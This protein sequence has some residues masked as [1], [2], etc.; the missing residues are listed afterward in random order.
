MIARAFALSA[1]TLSALPFSAL[2]ALAQD[3][4]SKTHDILVAGLDH[5]R[6]TLICA[7]GDAARQDEIKAIWKDAVMEIL[8][9]LDEAEVKPK[10]LPAIAASR[11]GGTLAL[12]D[13]EDAA[14]WQ[15]R[16]AAETS[17]QGDAALEAL[18]SLPSQVKDAL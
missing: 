14:E 5:A 4:A 6:L 1:L 12:R 8:M 9:A 11:D 13:G 15:A 16:C 3:A 17:W 7:E 10:V 2:P 18:K